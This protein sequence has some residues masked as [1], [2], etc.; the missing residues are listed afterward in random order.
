M[1]N[2]IYRHYTK[3][4]NVVLTTSTPDPPEF[5]AVYLEPKGSR[6]FCRPVNAFMEEIRLP[7]YRRIG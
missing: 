5:L 4:I 7:R 6:L 2:G 3:G 1:D